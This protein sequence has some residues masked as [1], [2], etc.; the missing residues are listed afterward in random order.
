MMHQGTVCTMMNCRFLRLRWTIAKQFAKFARIHDMKLMQCTR[1]RNIQKLRIT[2]GIRIA[3]LIGVVQNNCVKLKTFCERKWKH[4]DS[5]TSDYIRACIPQL[6][7]QLHYQLCNQLPH[8]L[9]RSHNLSVPLSAP[10]RHL[11]RS[12]QSFC[13]LLFLQLC[14]I[15]R[16][17]A[18]RSSQLHHFPQIPTWDCRDERSVSIR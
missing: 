17:H 1:Y 13:N 15:G 2:V 8:C 10:P 7:H 4:R 6:H 5:Y 18:H 14:S 9:C 11:D 3:L 16:L 12:E